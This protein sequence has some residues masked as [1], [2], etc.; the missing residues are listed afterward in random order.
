VARA[1]SHFGSCYIKNEIAYKIRDDL[2]KV[3]NETEMLWKEISRKKERNLICG[4]V[5]RHPSSSLDEFMD[6]LNSTIDIIHQENKLCLIMG[7]FNIDLMK[8]ESRPESSNFLDTLGSYFFQPFIL[9]PTRI[10]NHSA[11]LIDNVF[12]QLY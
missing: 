4:V 12:F 1:R 10:T 5:Y 2:T 6:L 8:I 11:T 3:T 9:Q 7:D